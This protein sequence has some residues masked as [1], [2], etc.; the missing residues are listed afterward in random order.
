MTY[1]SFTNS[2]AERPARS[3]AVGK[4]IPAGVGKNRLAALLVLAAG[5]EFLFVA[6]GAYCAA[7]LYHHGSPDAPKYIQESIL[8]AAMQLLVSVGLR[9]Y[10]RIQTQPRHVFLWS[11]VSAVLFV[12]AFF[13]STIFLLKVSEGYSRATVIAQAASVLVMVLCVRAICF[14]LL[15]PAIASGLIDA[16]RIILIGDPSHCLNFSARVIAT[17]IRTIRSFDFP[18]FRTGSSVPERSDAVEVPSHTRELI[19]ECR[20]LRADDIVILTSEVDVPAALAL[21]GALSELP[22]DVHVVPVGAVDL[23]AVSRIAQFG[24]M[25]TMRIF[26][27][28]LT[29]FHRAI[30]RSFDIA[31]AI[32]GLVVVS[33]LFVIL[34]LAIKLD[35]RGP[36]LFRQTR[37]GYNNETIRVVKFRS[38][39]VTEDGDNFKQVTRHDPR[40]TRLGRIMRQT[41]IDELPQLFNVLVGDMSLV[42]PRP[43]A[44]SQNEAFARLISSFSRRHNVKPGITGWA[45][46]NGHRGET[47]TLEKMRRRIEHDLYYIDNWSFLLDLKII[48]MTLFSRKVYWNAF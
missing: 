41:N 35:S 34:A 43:H 25:V 4:A 39:T 30:K 3:V 31:A 1:A 28:P 9:Q 27:S 36:V 48:V 24:N 23:M 12:F 42:G 46:V 26:Q 32:V 14:S 20:P 21:A 7:V 33:P 5:A 17:G 2:P 6:F 18:T 19:T 13:I 40:V 8:I 29:P 15:Q 16:R 44:T 22:A 11:G 45:Q 47:D 38:M 10:S 37:H